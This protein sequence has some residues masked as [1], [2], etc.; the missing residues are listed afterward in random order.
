MVV[1]ISGIVT[2]LSALEEEIAKVM[3]SYKEGPIV[4]DLKDIRFMVSSATAQIVKLYKFSKRKKVDFK[5][6]NAGDELYSMFEMLKLT[7]I[8]NIEK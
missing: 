8:L 5:I 3:N 2:N 7:Q 1:K 4:I 6:I